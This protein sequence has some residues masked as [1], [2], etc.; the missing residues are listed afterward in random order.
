[1]AS[2]ANVTKE[3]RLILKGGGIILGVILVL[4]FTIKG[5]TIFRNLFFPKPPP[6]P[7]Q[8]LGKLP[9]ITFPSQGTSGIQFRINTVDGQLPILPS[10]ANVYKLT[11]PEPNLLALEAAKKAVSSDG[12]SDNQIR[13]SDTVYQ[14]TQTRTG[15][16]IQYNIVTKNFTISSNYLTNP[17][18]ASTNLMPQQDTIKQDLS[19]FMQ[20]LSVDLSNIDTDK[21]TVELLEQNNG[22]LIAA[23]N[24]GNARF[25]RVTLHQKNVDD[26]PIIYDDP[27]NSI[28]TFIIS[29]PESNFKV[30]DAQFYNHQPD[31]TQKS[32][33]PTKSAAL[34]LEDLKNG[35]AYM[36]NP[37]NLTSVDI[38]NVELKYYL[39]KDSSDFLLPVIVFTGINFT[40][41]VE[42]IPST[43]LS[44]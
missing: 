10:R 18:L 34:A 3:T 7:E 37:Q 23:Q 12:F 14:W 27:N 11:Q 22:N 42:A 1:M 33:Y 40:A 39:N 2:L 24:L 32:D 44:N 15:I 28:L 13:L 29:Y 8:A 31:L 43:S 26:I 6:P 4:Y 16:N 36:I 38:T 21:T 30:V 25:A 41:Y 20:S 19:S 9:H 17:F 5:G 35:N